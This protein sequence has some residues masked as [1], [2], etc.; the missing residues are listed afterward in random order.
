VIVDGDFSRYLLIPW[1]EGDPTRGIP[2]FTCWTLFR[3]VY[4]D[5][6]CIELPAYDE[7][8]PLSLKK[9]SRA[10][11]DGLHSWGEIQRGQEKLMDGV[12]MFKG[13]HIGLVAG[14]GKMLH[15][16]RGRCSVIESYTAPRWEGCIDGFFRH[17]AG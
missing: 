15:L 9:V 2:R 4:W 6:L 8:P 1:T 14:P 13:T 5:K 16:E 17:G 3:T 12:L 10:V 11:H 7:V